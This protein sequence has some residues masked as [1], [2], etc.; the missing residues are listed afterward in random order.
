MQH[1]S[2]N[3]IHPTDMDEQIFS[4]LLLKMMNLIAPGESMKSSANRIKSAMEKM[5]K[6]LHEVSLNETAAN[7]I[8]EGITLPKEIFLL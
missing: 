7:I 4:E 6:N 5:L 2:M 8:T 3:E 1:Q